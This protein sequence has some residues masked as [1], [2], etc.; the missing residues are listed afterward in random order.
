MM[1]AYLLSPQGHCS[2]AF[3]YRGTYFFLLLTYHK[4]VFLFLSASSACFRLLQSLLKYTP[5]T[6]SLTFLKG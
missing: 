6:F 5:V 3:T 4:M 2:D 1:E